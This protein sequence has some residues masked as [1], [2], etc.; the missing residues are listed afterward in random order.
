MWCGELV[1]SNYKFHAPPQANWQYTFGDSENTTTFK[2]YLK[3]GPN[4][5]QRWAYYKILGVKWEKVN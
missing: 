1:M 4:A 3:K 2:F 5:F